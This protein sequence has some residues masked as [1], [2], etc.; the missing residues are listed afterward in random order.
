MS[1]T[2]RISRALTI[3]YGYQAVVAVVGL[4]L[5][6]LFLAYL[7]VTDYGRWLVV[8]QVLG[9]LGLL[10]LGVT[11]MLPREVAAATGA[12]DRSVR[13]P[14]VIRPAV[15]LVWL[16]TPVV[17]AVAA[18]AWAAVGAARPELAPPLAVVLAA[19]TLLY[20]LRVFTAVLNGLQDLE[21]VGVAQA[22]GWAVT[23]AIS[24]G[25]VVAGWGLYALAVG[26]AAGQAVT[27]AAGWWRVR[28][29]FPEARPR[30]RRPSRAR[31]WEYFRASLWVSLRQLAML[32]AGGCDL[33]ILGLVAGP[34]AVVVYSCTAK[35]VS[36]VN[37]LPLQIALNSLPALGEV[38]AVGDRDRLERTCRAVVLALL[39]L[40]G[41]AGPTVNW[42]IVAAMFTRHYVFTLVAVS[43][44]H[45]H[46]RRL[47]VSSMA[48]GILTAAAMF[49]WAAALGPVG[50]PLG[51]ITGS[52]LTNGLAGVWTLARDFRTSPVRVLGWAAPWAARVLAVGGPA[53]AATYLLPVEELPVGVGATAVVAAAY[54]VAAWPL[55]TRGVLRDY[56]DRLTAPFRRVGRPAAPGSRASASEVDYAAAAST[57]IPGGKLLPPGPG[58]S[59]NAPN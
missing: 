56:W 57:A 49:G 11:A 40:S 12:S 28:R 32:L 25:M 37:N 18:A 2:G 45:G 9:Y 44:I 21:F 38:R 1:R 39:L 50:I 59:P 58:D 7:G 22:A 54:A 30:G 31:L 29:R 10:D 36:F 34:A 33:I 14:E 5:T 55:L 6:P 19:Y 52:A 43:Y 35:L 48:D 4:W 51:S 16:Q 17:A 46:D 24:A 3:G 26:W 42:L 53:V 13:L 47:A 23:T 20:P 15:W 27:A 8:G 41:L